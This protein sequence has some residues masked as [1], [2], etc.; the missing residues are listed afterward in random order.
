MRREEINERRNNYESGKMD[1]IM[2]KREEFQN[3]K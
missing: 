1:E 2:R 3:G